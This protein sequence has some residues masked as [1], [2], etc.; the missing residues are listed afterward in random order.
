MW[1]PMRRVDMDFL[2]SADRR[3]VMEATLDAPRDRVWQAIADPRVWHHWFPGVEDAWY[4]GDPPYGVGTLRRAIVRGQRMEERML[5]WDEGERWAYCL[6]GASVPLARA[7]LECTELE[8]W[9]AG[10]RMR[11]TIA[12]DRGPL[13]WLATPVFQAVVSRLWRRAAGNLEA[14]LSD[15]R[16]R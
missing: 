3:W 9:G 10:T 12:A 8:D 5:A 16:E 14:W 13:L 11:W 4:E 2:D 15:P 6:L 7:Q 1:F